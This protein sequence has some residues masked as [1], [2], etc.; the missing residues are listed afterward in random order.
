MR[1]TLPYTYTY[2]RTMYKNKYNYLLLTVKK[3]TYS[4]FPK[5]KQFLKIRLYNLRNIVHNKLIH[6]N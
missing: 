1:E 5:I 6:A 2:I 3:D 4:F